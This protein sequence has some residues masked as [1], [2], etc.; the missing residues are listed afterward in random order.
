MSDVTI[1]KIRIETCVNTIIE[2]HKFLGSQRVNPEIIEQFR[3]LKD[4]VEV[5]NIG[6]VTEDDIEKIELATNS[7]LNEL[8]VLFDCHDVGDIYPNAKN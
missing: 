3:R 8:K 4:V 6:K 2:V 5:L 7:L 1:Y